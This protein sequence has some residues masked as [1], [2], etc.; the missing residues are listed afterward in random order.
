MR[1]PLRIFLY[2]SALIFLRKSAPAPA[3][4]SAVAAQR[5]IIGRLSLAASRSDPPGTPSER[6]V[7]TAVAKAVVDSRDFVLQP[8]LTPAD[9]VGET[10]RTDAGNLAAVKRFLSAVTDALL[11]VE[12][13]PGVR[14]VVRL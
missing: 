12:P 10:V 13:D 11:T 1:H 9:V 6:D 7:A 5:A 8:D 3:P 14:A 2:A 4:G